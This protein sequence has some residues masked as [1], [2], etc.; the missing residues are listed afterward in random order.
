MT[1]PLPDQPQPVDPRLRRQFAYYR[2][3]LGDKGVFAGTRHK[4]ITIDKS[5]MSEDQIKQLGFSPVL[6]A[7]PEAGQDQFTSYRHPNNNFH[8]HSHPGQWTMHEDSHPAATMLMKSRPTLWGKA[9]ALAEGIPHVV[10]EGIPGAAIYLGNQAKRMLPSVEAPDMLKAIFNDRQATKMQPK[11]A[12]DRGALAA[13]ATFKL[14]AFT[15]TLDQGCPGYPGCAGCPECQKEPAPMLEKQ[16]PAQGMQAGEFA[17]T[18]SA[19]PPTTNAAARS[20]ADSWY[21]RNQ[22]VNGQ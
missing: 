13:L 3:R 4:R 20:S 1:P 7:I 15:Q 19:R 21:H 10:T 2:Q 17:S 16:L 6:V 22:G 8:I 14:S 11:E 5:R 18:P 9:Q 12:Y